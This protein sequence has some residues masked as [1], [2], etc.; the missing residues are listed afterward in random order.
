MAN[1]PV[2]PTKLGKFALILFILALLAGAA[3]YFRDLVA[4][5]GGGP[6]D[7]DLD[8]FKQQQEV[9]AV[10]P[11]GITT[12]SEYSYVP[13][14]KLPPVQG[15]SNYDWDADE[16]VVQFPI[17]VWIGWLPIVAA[18]HGFKPNEESIF[19]KEHGFRVNLKLI[20]DPVVARDAFA[21]GES[22][23]LWGTLDMMT[24]FA[25]ELM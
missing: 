1:E 23:V 18:N 25:P 3:Y 20:D 14:E 12:V 13:T 10:D 21:S 24:L 9:E 7:V 15:V 4:P 2:G 22:H 5:S 16:K 19:F 17:N 11:T 8:R 6:G